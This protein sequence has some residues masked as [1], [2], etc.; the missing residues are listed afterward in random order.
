LLPRDQS[1]LELDYSCFGLFILQTFSELSFTPPT[2]KF[3]VFQHQID[4]MASATGLPERLPGDTEE[5]G[6]AGRETEPLLGRPGDVAQEEGKSSL[7]NLVLGKF[8]SKR[9]SHPQTDV[10]VVF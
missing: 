4:D 6:L 8:P 3:C 9:L 2:R 7:N 1:F 5:T 10:K